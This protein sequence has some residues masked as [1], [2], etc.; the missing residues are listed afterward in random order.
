RALVASD[1][2]FPMVSDIMP[3]WQINQVGPG[4]SVEQ[5]G[6]KSLVIALGKLLFLSK[7]SSVTAWLILEG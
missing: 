6:R 5:M 4:V 7:Y 1:N 2:P 3:S